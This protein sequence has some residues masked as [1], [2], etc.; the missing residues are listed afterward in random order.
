MAALPIE[1]SW[2][3]VEGDH[4][5]FDTSIV[6]NTFGASGE[7]GTDEGDDPFVSG[8][9]GLPSQQ[10]FSGSVAA[11]AAA[12][13]RRGIGART[14][15]GASHPGFSSSQE[16]RTSAGGDSFGGS[17]SD[18]IYS[19]LRKAENNE[20]VIMRSPFQPSVPSSVRQTPLSG[21]S[22][23]RANG[24][25]KVGRGGRFKT[26]EPEFRMPTV[27][28]DGSVH[29]EH[30]HGLDGLHQRGAAFRASNTGSP[31][32]RHRNNSSRLGGRSKAEVG[33]NGGLLAVASPIWSAA[34]WKQTL[35]SWPALL[36]LVSLVAAY[37]GAASLPSNLYTA[38]TRTACAAPGVSRLV[39]PLCADSRSS[40]SSLGPGSG[41]A[42]ASRSENYWAVRSHFRDDIK[43]AADDEAAAPVS[44][45][46]S[47]S[48]LMHLQ[49]RLAGIVRDRI[50]TRLSGIGAN[51]PGAKEGHPTVA[52]PPAEDAWLVPRARTRDLLL[53]VQRLQGQ[54][55][56]T[57]PQQQRQQGQQPNQEPAN[58]AT[59]TLKELDAYL[60]AARQ[61]SVA[62]ARLQNGAANAAADTLAHAS[63]I[64]VTQLRRMAAAVSRAPANG[65][66]DTTIA[67]AS[68]RESPPGW[69]ARLFSSADAH[70]SASRRRELIIDAYRRHVDDLVTR[71]DNRVNEATAVLKALDGANQH[72]IAVEGYVASRRDALLA[73]DGAG[74]QDSA[75]AGGSL[76]GPD[77]VHGG[78][79]FAWLWGLFFA[80]QGPDGAA[81]S[82]PW[83]A[84]FGKMRKT[85]RAWVGYA[86][87]LQH[88]REDHDNAVNRAAETLDE[89]AAVRDALT[90]VQASLARAGSSTGSVD[91]RDDNDLNMRLHVDIVEAGIE[92]LKAKS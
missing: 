7:Y 22:A 46:R 13:A 3:M 45:V 16:S 48:E 59:L 6:P 80:Q 88:I 27:D 78:G 37:L 29:A 50:P 68:V 34:A 26:P 85:T 92:D 25:A 89:L 74:G 53:A 82:A 73:R 64:T 42:D 83:P 54:E 63:R 60:A 39:P 75:A 51:K 23:S 72:L 91:V 76:D 5:S 55:R 44:L 18:D 70:A 87:Q 12:A 8:S 2:R 4:D 65:V 1:S 77:A 35:V 69:L 67:S 19:F 20:D 32:Q 61:V 28:M 17:Q 24:N 47:A 36:L 9:S 79:L 62:M 14:T 66:T 40:S 90:A 31:A 11:A 52:L 43:K 71:A 81:V 49:A 38:V 30:G 86:D 57:P 10:S 84:S 33:D 21:S 58:R 15:S 41:G 56:S